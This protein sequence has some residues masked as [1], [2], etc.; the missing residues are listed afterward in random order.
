MARVCAEIAELLCT[1]AAEPAAKKKRPRKAKRD[2][3]AIIKE[4]YPA[5]E[6]KPEGTYVVGA[7]IPAGLDFVRVQDAREPAAE[8]RIFASVADETSGTAKEI[9]SVDDAYL[10]T[11]AEGEVIRLKRAADLIQEGRYRMGEISL[12]V[13]FSNHSY[14]SKLFCRQFGMT[15]KDFEKQIEEQRTKTKNLRQK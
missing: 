10:L 1:A 8:V 2:R 11:L 3:E 4:R 7:E 6:L 12:M 9:L 13:G 5:G 15:P 14:F